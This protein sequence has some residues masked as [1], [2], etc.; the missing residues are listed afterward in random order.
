MS[1]RLIQA[2]PFIFYRQE[3]PVCTP[4]L[5]SFVGQHADLPLA[6][7]PDLSCNQSFSLRTMNVSFLVNVSG[8]PHL[9]R[10]NISTCK[11]ASRGSFH[12][13]PKSGYVELCPQNRQENLHP[14]TRWSPP[15]ECTFQVGSTRVTTITSR[16][17]HPDLRIVDQD[18]GCA[19]LLSQAASAP[20]TV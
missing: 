14:S 17:H 12:L 6:L 8:F 20:G 9:H 5:F 10:S 4:H 16:D 2:F 19:N 3:G 13:P 1:T 15:A 11:V 7:A 18:S